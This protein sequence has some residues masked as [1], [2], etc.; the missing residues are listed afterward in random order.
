MPTINLKIIDFG[1][2]HGSTDA[3]WEKMKD[4]TTDLLM[5]HNAECLDAFRLY[6]CSADRDAPRHADR[7][8]R[9]AI[10]YHPL[11]LYIRDTVVPLQY[12]FPRVGGTFR[13][14]RRLQLV[15]LKLDHSFAELL[16]SGCPVL[17]DLVLVGCH[18]SWHSIQFTEEHLGKCLSED[19]DTLIIR[20]PC[21]ASLRLYFPCHGYGNGVSL[22]MNRTFFLPSVR[23]I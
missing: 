10:K 9:R 17:E 5:L 19:A 22:D 3:N 20:A 13:R 21:L 23:N 4:F 2:L 14:L 6:F 7:W 15:A 12:Q 11:V 18:I 1:S 8:I 16:H